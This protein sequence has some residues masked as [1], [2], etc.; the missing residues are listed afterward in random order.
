M[1]SIVY[2]VPYFGKLPNLFGLW[3]KSCEYNP[4]IDW[5]LYIDDR[6]VYDYP[7]NV[8]VHYISFDEMK[9]QIQ[10]VF[11]FH[12]ELSHPYRLCDYR[13][14]YGRIFAKDIQRYDFWGFCDIDLI[15]GDIRFFLKD[16]ILETYDKI[17][18]LGHS[19]LFRNIERMN[20]LYEQ[21]LGEEMLYKAIFT[22][23]SNQNHFFDERGIN[24]LCEQYGIKIYKE[25]IFADLTPLTWNFQI[26]YASELEFR[27]NNHRLFVWEEGKL[28]SY[29]LLRNNICKDEFMY[30]HFL[31][32][33]INIEKGL[34]SVDK[35]LIVPNRI[36]KLPMEITNQIIKKYSRN[37]MFFY[38]IDL[39]IAKWKKIGLRNLILYFHIR[40]K[41]MK[42]FNDNKLNNTGGH[43]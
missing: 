36:I 5:L 21:S 37:R 25:T 32:R 38:W 34:H 10:D 20:L 26:N 39:F 14:A 12:I 29:S 4:T 13:V 2:I 24:Q 43:D 8:K 33:R 3:L 40:R 16:C 22:D 30:V 11:P 28:Y 42:V 19:T 1:K 17:G 15:F 35:F 18:Y 27:K 6:S 31:R 41:A 23:A 7:P 9:K